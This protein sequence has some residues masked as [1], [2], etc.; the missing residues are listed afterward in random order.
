MR[1]CL[2]WFLYHSSAFNFLFKNLRGYCK[3]V[4]NTENNCW[5]WYTESY[6]FHTIDTVFEQRQ[7]AVLGGNG[8]WRQWK[9]FL[10]KKSVSC[11]TG[12]GENQSTSHFNKSNPVILVSYKWKY[13]LAWSWQTLAFDDQFNCRDFLGVSS[14]FV[15]LFVGVFLFV[16]CNSASVKIGGSPKGLE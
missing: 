5:M 15:L 7:L 9:K 11:L 13:F 4:L 6:N 8:I 1:C 3:S 16:F 12:W 2:F 10:S 14:S